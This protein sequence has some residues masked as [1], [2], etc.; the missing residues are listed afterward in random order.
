MKIPAYALDASMIT[1]KTEVL[2]NDDLFAIHSEVEAEL[3]KR[4]VWPPKP[5][6]ALEPAETACIRGGDKIA[7]IKLVR[8]RHPD[9]LSLKEAKDIVDQ[10]ERAHTGM[11]GQIARP[12]QGS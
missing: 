4:G 11:G 2:M 6:V 5:V 9:Q 12:I 10:Y 7:A 8:A 3:R 1:I